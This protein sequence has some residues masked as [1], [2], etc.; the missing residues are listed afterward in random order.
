[1]PY[2]VIK[3]RMVRAGLTFL[4]ILFLTPVILALDAQELLKQ[5][6]EH[7]N[8]GDHFAFEM[9]ISSFHGAEKIDNYTLYGYVSI[10]ADRK[11]KTGSFEF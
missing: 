10:G 6:D 3:Q 8:A 2:Y 5:A 1:M 9:E 7:L 11:T 4:T